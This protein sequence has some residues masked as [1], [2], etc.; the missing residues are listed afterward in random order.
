MHK[1]KCMRNLKNINNIWNKI[2]K[3]QIK[4]S[5]TNNQINACFGSK[6]QIHTQ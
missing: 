2:M 5:E 1:N 6:K 3:Y 4:K